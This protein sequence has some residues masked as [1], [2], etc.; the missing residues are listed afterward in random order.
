MA[1]SLK[2]IKNNNKRENKAKLTFRN[3][4]YDSKFAICTMCGSIL[5]IPPFCFQFP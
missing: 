2:C 5:T 1:P 4:L 3:H